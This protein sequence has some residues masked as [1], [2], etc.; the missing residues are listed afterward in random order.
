MKEPI[1]F[2]MA[3]FQK[4]GLGE[5]AEHYPQ[6]VYSW[7]VMLILILGT[8]LVRGKINPFNPS[9][10][11]SFFETLIEG[12][13]NFM[14]DVMGEEGRFAF[15]I[16]ATLF[17]YIFLCNILGLMP[18][19]YSPTANINT[20]LS[21]ALVSFVMTHVIGLKFHGVKYIKHFTGPIPWLIPLFFPIEVIGH[22]ARVLSLTFR[23]FGNIMAEDLVL[24]ILM[25]LAGAYLA[26]LPMM[27]LFIFA[28]F[29]QAF[30]FTLLTMMYFAGAIE[31]AH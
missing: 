16:I 11:Q 12:I 18:G 10:L 2:L 4:V 1:L 8:L 22:C 15:P 27:F 6:V 3:L 24:A 31:E 23:L 29:V 5:F 19:M 26:P 9:R 14:V 17:L 7:L 30:I 13:E 21:C 20:T 28:D 25:F